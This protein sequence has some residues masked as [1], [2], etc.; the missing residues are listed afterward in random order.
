MKVY[1]LVKRVLI[2]NEQARNSDKE[3]IWEVYRELGIVKT[4]EWFGDREA[5]MKDQFLSGKTPSTET[6]RRTRQ[7][8]QEK[9]LELGATSSTV[10]AKRKQKEDSKGTFIFRAETT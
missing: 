8:I 1:D 4:V 6:I 9:H 5:I 10:K 3:C 7:K 2:N